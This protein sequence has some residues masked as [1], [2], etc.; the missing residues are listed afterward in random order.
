MAP[1]L[2][3]RIRFVIDGQNIGEVVIPI[4]QGSSAA[5]AAYNWQ[6]PELSNA[7]EITWRTLAGATGKVPIPQGIT[8]DY[9]FQAMAD[10]D[11]KYE[12]INENNNLSPEKTLTAYIP[13]D[14]MVIYVQ[15]TDI[16]GGVPG[17][18]VKLNTASGETAAVLSD[19]NGWC[20]FTGVTAGQCTLTVT[21]EG[22]E[23]LSE[24]FTTEDGTI[25]YTKYYNMQ[26][27]S[28][29]P[30]YCGNDSDNDLVSDE[31]EVLYGLKPND[32]DTDKDGIIDGKDLSPLINP[33]EPTFLY[34]QKV[35][36]VRL[37]Q[38][39]EACGLD[40]WVEVWD[41]DFHLSSLSNELVY[42]RTYEDQGTRK[43]TMNQETYQRAVNKLFQSE[44]LKSYKIKDIGPKDLNIGNK[45]YTHD[46]NA[47]DTEIFPA[48]ALHRTEYR[49]YYDYLTDYQTVS[50]KN[51]E[52]IC[53]PSNDDCLN[54]LLL[55]LKLKDGCSHKYSIQFVQS[56]L[57]EKI[58]HNSDSDYQELGFQYS[59]Y[60]TDNFDDDN[61]I[62]Y[63][64]GIALV[65]TDGSDLFSFSVEI[66]AGHIPSG[67]DSSY[68]KLTPIWIENN[69][70][71]DKIFAANIYWDITGITRE[72]IIEEQTDG[73]CKTLKE[74]FGSV[75][76]FNNPIMSYQDILSYE[77]SSKSKTTENWAG[78][79]FYNPDAPEDE[80]Y[81][82]VEMQLKILSYVDKTVSTTAKVFSCVEKGVTEVK[83]VSKIENLPES[84]WIRQPKY[85]AVLAGL[86]VAQGAVAIYTDGLEAWKAYKEGDTITCVYYSAKAAGA[87]A[88]TTVA[89]A[90]I[91]KNVV[92]WSA[93]TGRFAKLAC[94]EV[95]IALAAIMGGIEVIYYTLKYGE[96]EDAIQ[97]NAYKEKMS[98][99]CFDTAFSFVGIAYAPFIAFQVTWTIGVELYRLVCGNDLAYSVASSPSKA[100]VFIIY[101]WTEQV[102]SQIAEPAYNSIRNDLIESIKEENDTGKI[103]GRPY[104]SVFIDPQI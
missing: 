30:I 54:Y 37:D 12:E 61:N 99:A 79:V 77:N 45:E 103:F 15:I 72:V 41:M 22:Y 86:S 39:I 97:Q 69:Q 67:T 55:P 100:I 14:R 18:E 92:A 1:A 34:L 74:H 38:P 31:N 28:D 13:Y 16:L 11:N 85:N 91:S 68:L 36:M 101:Y 81:R 46:Y 25:Q 4:I 56:G 64:Q 65:D 29:T 51:F 50:L 2:N 60:K 89:L 27:T 9:T 8:K 70:G 40:G 43:S 23:T 5:T 24:S 73:S 10:S 95:G 87:V 17:A 44:K 7:A 58:F 20:S 78:M 63:C 33:I 53:F 104:I 19:E 52:E 48:D 3:Q 75:E 47:E 32:A 57:A 83:K 42:S 62:P 98:A 35:G 94:D 21:K 80:K 93:K 76:G 96:T 66:P 84:Y 90:S 88:D 49:F 26:R 71:S 6:I 59:F 102:P 82:I